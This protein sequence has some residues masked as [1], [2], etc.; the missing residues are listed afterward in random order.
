M[1]VALADREPNGLAEML[2]NLLEAN[3]AARP[4]RRALLRPAVVELDAVDAQVEATVRISPGAVEVSN[5]PANPGAQVRIDARAQD[6]LA[7]A[8]A[9]LL[10]GLPNPFRRE[11]RNVLGRVLRRE[12]RIDG[13]LRHPVVLSRFARLLSVA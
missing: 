1:R 4:R 5:G 13:M 8:A 3:L 10:L 11:G 6:L 9:P 2:A 12:V 7:M